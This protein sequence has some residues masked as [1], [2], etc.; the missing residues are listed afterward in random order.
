M[1]WRVNYYSGEVQD[2][3]HSISGPLQ[4][5]EKEVGAEQRHLL[6]SVKKEVGEV[7]SRD[8]YWGSS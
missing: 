2:I 8:R 6:E 7:C 1:S 4:E 3:K 5:E